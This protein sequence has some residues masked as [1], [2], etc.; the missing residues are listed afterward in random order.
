MQCKLNGDL[1]VNPYVYLETERKNHERKVK[2]NEEQMEEVFARKVNEKL[3][4]LKNW[5]KE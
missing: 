2:D 4:K 1:V 5:E 3:V